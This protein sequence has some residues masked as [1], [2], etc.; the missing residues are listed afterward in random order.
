MN[1]LV[2]CI[3]CMMMGLIL[4][5]SSSDNAWTDQAYHPSISEVVLFG[6]RPIQELIPAQY[7]EQERPCVTSYLAAIPQDSPLSK[8]RPP[9]GP[10]KAVEVRR[11]NM[12]QQIITILGENAR[13]EGELFASAVPLSAEWEGMSEGPVDEAN[14]VDNWLGNRPVT[15]IT[16]APF[17]YLFKAHRLRAGY[18]AAKFGHEKGLWP[19]LAKRYHESL[20]KAKSFGNPLISCIADDLDAQP[21]VY[22]ENQGRP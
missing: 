10:E 6:I 21:Y 14:F 11:Q 1:P 4:N 22:L 13:K 20:E 12:A 2:R 5:S 9:S 18:E 7:P 3:I 15:S 17:L 19:I 8:H 16:I